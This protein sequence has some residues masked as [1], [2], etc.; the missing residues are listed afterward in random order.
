M[1]RKMINQSVG[2]I[3]TRR[4]SVATIAWLQS[5]NI[6][7][8]TLVDAGANNSQWMI[9]LSKAFPGAKVIS[10]EPQRDC[11]PIGVWHKVGLGKEPGY[12][13]ISGNGTSAY[14]K[15]SIIGDTRIC[16]LDDFKDEFI[17]PALLKVDCE[18]HTY[19][20]L[21][22]AQTVLRMFSSVVVEIWESLDYSGRN[23]HAVIHNLMWNNG[24]NRAMTVGA[25][26]WRNHVSIT[27]SLFWKE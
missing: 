10:F 2:W 26:A 22:G 21:L 14:L 4:S 16:L 18:D 27:D 20:A 7:P 11:N 13:S 3:D 19:D 6:I 8:L 1:L 12:A 5:R 23:K 24:F 17:F 9:R 15:Q 25:T